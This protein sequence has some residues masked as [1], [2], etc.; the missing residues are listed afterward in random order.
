[1]P[2]GDRTGPMGLGA[3]R[4][5]AAGFCS[6]YDVPGYA[7]TEIPRGFGMGRNRMNPGWCAFPGG[8]RGRRQG[9]SAWGPQRPGYFGGY[10]AAPQPFNPELEKETLEN[11]ILA[12]KSELEAIGK[13]LNELSSQEKEP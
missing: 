1:M 13:R 10:S 3:R 5:R 6:G 2:K 9:Y 7:N 8:G 12:L 4:G 11:R